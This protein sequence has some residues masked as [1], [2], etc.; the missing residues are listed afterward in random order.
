MLKKKIVSAA[1]LCAVL[2]QAGA[3]YAY[4]V[5]IYIK[6]YHVIRDIRN[7]DGYD[8]LPIADIAGELGYTYTVISDD[9][10]SVTA[11]NRT[12]DFT[13][14]DNMAYDNNGGRYNL[15]TA[16]QIM[17]GAVRIPSNFFTEILD[18][19]YIWDEY[20]HAV[21]IDA[22][23]SYDWIITTPEYQAAQGINVP[24]DEQG[25]VTFENL[26]D[27]VVKINKYISDG[28][29]IEA[30]Q[31]CE[32]TLYNHYASPSDILLINSLKEKAS[33]SYNAFLEQYGL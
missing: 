15:G 27:Q 32:Q 1:A 20:I 25:Y 5:D 2:L 33:I 10:F 22:Q 13:I 31:Y 16:P 14:N 18:V 21:F 24:Q 8:M 11:N 6:S 4:D 9:K 3:A 29:Y 7:V 23:N 17:E 30:M 19:G 12:Y 28:L 26:T